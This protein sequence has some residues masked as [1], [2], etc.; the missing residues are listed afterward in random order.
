MVA[1]DNGSAERV[2]GKARSVKREV[3]ELRD[4]LGRA[5]G[6]VRARLDFA[7]EVNTHPIRT[8]L[9]AAGIGYVLGGGLFSRTTR[10]LVG[11]GMRL[12]LLPMVKSQL[13]SMLVGTTATAP[14]PTEGST[15]H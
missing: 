9:V 5:A 14:V 8:V 4:E 1:E 10:T 2:L 3:K 15:Q 6:E 13:E 7:E 12:M 11:T